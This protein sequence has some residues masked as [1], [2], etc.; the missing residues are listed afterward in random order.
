MNLQ[1]I[2]KARRF[3][4]YYL[5]ITAL[6][7]TLVL[8][9]TLCV[10]LCVQWTHTFFLMEMYGQGGYDL[11]FKTRELKKKWLEQFEMAL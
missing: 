3:N 2:E 4:A 6:H 8:S 11:F 1:E 10:C 7:M 9:Q 5:L